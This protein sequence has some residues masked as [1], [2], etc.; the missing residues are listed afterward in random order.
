MTTYQAAMK[1]LNERQAKRE[2]LSHISEKK[3]RYDN[4]QIKTA[5]MNIMDINNKI[6]IAMLDM[7]AAKTSHIVHLILTLL[8][9]GLWLIVWLFAAMITQQQR[10]NKQRYIRRLIKQRS[11][12][13]KRMVK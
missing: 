8:T 3:I 2:T 13:K 11:E 12:I 5:P 9:G 10:V 4:E 6:D 1:R 7:E